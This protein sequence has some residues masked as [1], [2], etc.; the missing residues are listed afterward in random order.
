M[1]VGLAVSF[2]NVQIFLVLAYFLTLNSSKDTNSSVHE[3]TF[4]RAVKLLLLILG[5]PWR[6]LSSVVSNLPN[7]TFIFHDF[8]GPTI[9]FHDFPGFP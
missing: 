2:E 1:T 7:R 4:V 9:K 8:Q 6:A 3:N 5:C